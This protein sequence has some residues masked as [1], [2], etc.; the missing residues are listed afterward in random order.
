[1]GADP[2]VHSLWTRTEK[3]SGM[4]TPSVGVRLRECKF[5]PRHYQDYFLLSTASECHPVGL[6]ALRL[7]RTNHRRDYFEKMR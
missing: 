4:K 1:M 2:T 5:M 7:H 6:A 3:P